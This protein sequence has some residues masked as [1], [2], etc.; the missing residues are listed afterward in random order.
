MNTPAADKGI[1]LAIDRLGKRFGGLEAVR[2]VSL[3]VHRGEVVALIGPNGA[4]KSTLFEMIG[5]NVEPS[6]GSIRYFG[7]DVTFAPAHARRRAG[8]CRT[9]QKIRLFESLTVEQ[10]IAVAATHCVPKRE[11]GDVVGD[12]MRRL[13]LSDKARR[14]PGE[15][16]L[17]D[18]KKVEIG[19]AMV[20]RC[21]VLL[22]D[23]SLSGLTHDE[24]DHMS[25]EILAL[26]RDAGITI[27]LV[28]H[29]MS[30]VV[31]MAKRLIVLNQGAVIADGTPE[32]IA[33]DARVIEAYLGRKGLSLGR[34]GAA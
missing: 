32:A 29:V 34:G 23:E 25:G 11:R 15:L 21:N 31:A 5:G 28:E 8:L 13:H 33:S 17:A 30:V 18:R 10:N 9:Y 1:A 16:T 2:D 12:V 3:T 22:L 14:L 20:G 24:A 19:R 26:N 4:G 7:E 6:S 27:I